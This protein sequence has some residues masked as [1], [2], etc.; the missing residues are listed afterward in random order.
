M[1]LPLTV[2]NLGFKCLKIEKKKNCD[3]F[4][5]PSQELK[6]KPAGFRV[7]IF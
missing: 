2:L 3:S 7:W 4:K 1:L 5:M 6:E